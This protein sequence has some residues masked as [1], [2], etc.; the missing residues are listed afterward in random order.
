MRR[1]YIRNTEYG[2]QGTGYKEDKKDLEHS[3]IRHAIKETEQSN[4][5]KYGGRGGGKREYQKL[6]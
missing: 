6:G 2:V 4:K 5:K 3:K 1:T